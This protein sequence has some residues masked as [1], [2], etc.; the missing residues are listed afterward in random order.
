MTNNI[1]ILSGDPGKIRDSFFIV[2]TEIKQNKLYVR[3]SVRRQG[4]AYKQVCAEYAA[5]SKKHGFKFNLIEANNT[6]QFVIEELE[7]VHHIPVI[8]VT[9]TKDIK[10]E[11]KKNVVERMDKNENVKW[12]LNMKAEHRI[13]FPT[14]ENCSAD[15]LEL[16]RQIAIFAEHKT[17]AGSV[18]YYAP[19]SE[20]DD[21]VMALLINCQKAKQYLKVG[22]KGSYV[23]GQLRE[24]PEEPY[25]TFGFA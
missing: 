18:S 15:M 20:H 7:Q 4:R 19:G 2:G 5:I 23:G 17:E 13:I 16:K 12:F 8:G 11:K 1:K 21:G 24:V 25:G 14:D 6:G 22:G 10:D 9:T 3:L